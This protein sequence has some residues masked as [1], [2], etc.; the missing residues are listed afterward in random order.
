MKTPSVLSSALGWLPAFLAFCLPLHPRMSSWLLLAWLPL[1]VWGGV[2]G[3]WKRSRWSPAAWAMAA[4]YG[5]HVCGLAWTEDLSVGLFALE[6]KAAL[7]L[8][9]LVFNTLPNRRDD[10]V[11][12]M[13]Q[14]GAL[15]ILVARIV[16]AIAGWEGAG[17]R[18]ADFTGPFH[19]TY[20]A[21]YWGVAVLFARGDRSRWLLPIFAMAIGL[22]ASKAGWIGGGFALLWVWGAGGWKKMALPVLLGTAALALSAGISDRGRTEEFVRNS[23]ANVDVGQDDLKEAKGST[24]G[25]MQAWSVAWEFIQANPIWG[26]GT[27]DVEATLVP[28]YEA[29]GLAYAAHHRMNPHNAYLQAAL[30]LGLLGLLGLLV[31]WGLVAWR[32]WKDQIWS[33]LGILLLI[34]MN[35]LFESILELQQGIVAIVLLTFI[36]GDRHNRRLD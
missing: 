3:E 27:G 36:A 18:Y 9:P 24:G 10:W 5:L 12:R 16:A 31:W 25:R 15:A 22:A 35:G 28:A 21:M 6:E 17:W 29:Q 11:P 4:F 26:V 14:A 20:L 1:W 13:W 2:R 34:A 33:H 23:T 8:V 30:S 19:P 7:L 32:A